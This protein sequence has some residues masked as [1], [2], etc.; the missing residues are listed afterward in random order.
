MWNE[1][2]KVQVRNADEPLEGKIGSFG[3]I[4]GNVEIFAA[5]LRYNPISSENPKK[6]LLLKNGE[7]KGYVYLSATWIGDEEEYL[8][9]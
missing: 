2:F 6:Y 3:N 8:G 5:E 4:I 7:E 1:T 9:F